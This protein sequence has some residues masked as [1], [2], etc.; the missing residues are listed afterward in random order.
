[1]RFASPH[2]LSATPIGAG[3]SRPRRPH[4]ATRSSSIPRAHGSLSRH[5]APGPTG[6]GRR[7]AT[8]T[9][10]TPRPSPPPTRSTSPARPATTRWCW[11][12]P[13]LPTPRTC[14][15]YVWNTASS[16]TQVHCQR[17]WVAGL[18]WATGRQI[19][20]NTSRPKRRSRLSQERLGSAPRSRAGPCVSQ[21]RPRQSSEGV[22][23]PQ[24]AGNLI[25]TIVPRRWWW[26]RKRPAISV[27]RVSG[28]PNA[29]RAWWRASAARCA[30]RRSR[31]RR[32]GALGRRRVLAL[33]CL[34][35]YRLLRDMVRSFRPLS[36]RCPV[37]RTLCP[38]RGGP[39]KVIHLLSF[40]YTTGLLHRHSEGGHHAGQNIRTFCGE[41]SSFR[42]GTWHVGTRPG[43]GPTR[44]LVCPDGAEAVHPYL[45]VF[46][47]LCL[48]QPGR[49]SQQA[50][51]A[52]SLSGPRRRGW[53]LPHR[54]LQQTQRGR[55]PH[56]G[57]TG[58][59]E[60][61]GIDATYRA[62]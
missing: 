3:S 14:A 48:A 11:P 23:Q 34:L 47:R 56:L 37:R 38:L 46:N 51:G 4:A 30:W 35:A 27:T 50:L 57:S 39:V 5:G 8:S 52:C 16:Q 59:L 15:P 10:T 19:G 9:G 54:G 43:S 33:A 21:P 28:R 45:V 24:S 20:S 61:C 18:V 26:R 32:A 49:L 13:H 1:M 31:W 58:A 6:A 60:G 7:R 42:H 22:R 17:L 2:P 12:L 55:D 44:C 29:S 62:A 53:G 40:C 41:K 25:P 36:L